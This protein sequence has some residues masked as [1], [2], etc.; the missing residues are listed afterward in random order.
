M[1]SLLAQ[2]ALPTP[3][4]VNNLFVNAAK[5]RG[6]FPSA[7]Y[8]RWRKAAAAALGRVSPISKRVDVRIAVNEGASRA[9]LDNL[10]KAP[11]DLLVWMKVL[12]G[13]SKKYIRRIE[14]V[15]VPRSDP[16]QFVVQL[17]GESDEDAANDAASIS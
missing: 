2:F 14:L 15:W 10:A 5:G 7:R 3:P 9:D 16:R 12:G 11:L 1:G 13:D 6:R 17:W 8:A 4:A